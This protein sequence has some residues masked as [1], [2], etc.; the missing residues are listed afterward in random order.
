MFETIFKITAPISTR[1]KS[2]VVRVYALLLSGVISAACACW[3]DMHYTRLGGLMTALVGAM[4]FAGVRTGSSKAGNTGIAL[5]L[6]GAA[7]EGMSLSPL[8]HTAMR[9]YPQALTTALLTSIAVFGSFSVAAIFA[10]R[11]EYLFLSGICGTVASFLFLASLTNI[12]VRS[13]FVMD[14][15][16]YVGLAMFVSYVLIDTQLMIERFEESYSNVNIVKPACDLFVDLIA[17]FVRILIIL[18]R[19]NQRK[20]DRSRR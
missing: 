14:L 13:S 8:V 9:Y 20:N 11:R 3:V 5:F 2:L 4:I 6:A 10:K 18:M 19:K 12:F 7:L 17:V 1:T 15:Q 16:V